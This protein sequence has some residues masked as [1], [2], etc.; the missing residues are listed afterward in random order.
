MLKTLAK[1]HYKLNN[2][3]RALYFMEESHRI[4]PTDVIILTFIVTMSLMV[5]CDIDKG[6]KYMEELRQKWGDEPKTKETVS[7]YGLYKQS[8]W[9]IE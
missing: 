8:I 6:R 1:S 2:L 7:Q 4:D 9:V 3:E 5:Q